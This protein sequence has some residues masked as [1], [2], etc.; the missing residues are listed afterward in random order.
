V[1]TLWESLRP[2]RR[3]TLACV[4]EGSAAIN[5]CADAKRLPVKQ[6]GYRTSAKSPTTT[7]RSG[8]EGGV[9]VVFY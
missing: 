7:H 2:V 6:S 3:V 9:V 4:R 1:T 5:F 8:L